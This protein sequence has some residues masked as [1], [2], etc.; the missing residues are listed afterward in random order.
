MVCTFPR[1]E[2]GLCGVKARGVT[3][4]DSDLEGARVLPDFPVTTFL[5]LFLNSR[6]LH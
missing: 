3:E 5:V 4:R 1:Q 6:T 2:G